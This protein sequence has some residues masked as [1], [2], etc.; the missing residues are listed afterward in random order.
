MTPVRILIADD[1]EVVRQGVRTVL[2]GHPGWVVCGEAS[3]G[4]E[5]V[6]KAIDLRPDVVVLDISM[7]QLN[8][9]EATRQLRRAV[10]AKILILTVHESDQVVTEVLDAG[11]HGYLLK[12]DAGR[13]LVEAIRALL[14]HKEFI[15]ERVHVV[16]ARRSG[17]GRAAAARRGSG[18]LSP[19]EREV[20]QLLTEGKT[21]KEI[22]VALG[23]TTKTAETHRTHIMAKLNLHSMSE[24]VRYAIRNRII[25]A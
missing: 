24:L 7:P 16:A 13:K 22:G 14:R 3:T 10:P 1:H 18:R 20:L 5:A 11:A 6:A 25:E 15:S 21:N 17:P 9:L 8:G 12:A 19:R 23:M 4:R 2:E